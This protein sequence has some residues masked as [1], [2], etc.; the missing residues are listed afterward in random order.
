MRKIK[1]LEERI[2]NLERLTRCNDKIRTDFDNFLLEKIDNINARQNE[3]E[4]KQKEQEEFLK[5]TVAPF[6]ANSLKE[7][8]TELTDALAELLKVE[9]KIK[10]NKKTDTKKTN[11][12]KTKKESK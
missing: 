5:N 11:K 8:L 3:I 10:E 1:E 9:P 7:G 6:I 12:T 2:D 4:S